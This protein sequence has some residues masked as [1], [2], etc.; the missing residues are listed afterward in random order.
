MD[1]LSLYTNGNLDALRDRTD[2]LA[3]QAVVALIQNPELISLMN[4][5]DQIPEVLPQDWPLQLLNF[6]NYY[7]EIENKA[8]IALLKNGQKFFQEKGDLYLAMLGFYSLPYCYAFAD[9]AEVL[10]RSNRIVNQIGE[11]LGETGIFLLE[12]FR[13]GAFYTNKVAYWTCAKV[14]LIHAFSR[15]FVERYARDWNPDFGKPI[16]QEDLIGTNLAFSLMVLRGFRKIGVNLS[17][18]ESTTVINY[19]HW[20]GELMGLEV[21]FWPVTAKE[22]FE[23]ERLIRKRHLKYSKAGETLI[24]ALIKFYEDSI[25]DPILSKQAESIVSFFVG[26]EASKALGLN[27]TLR[28]QGDLLGLLFRFT[29]F[30]TYGGKKDFRSIENQ[31]RA[32]QLEQ[33]G[34]VL[35]VQLPSLKRS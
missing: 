21:Q 35:Q 22:A 13:P 32:N 20:V 6:L 24:R 17:T 9:G 3:D 2:P 23:L 16:N 28:I 12:L 1:K 5:W 14:R 25:P 11:R 18:Q 30:Q 10:V 7:Q 4:S 27:Q 31:F 34:K 26:E 8:P 29:G 33:F 15:Y 19:W